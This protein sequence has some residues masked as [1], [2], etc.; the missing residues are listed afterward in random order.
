M[1]G[2]GCQVHFPSGYH[3]LFIYLKDA[4]Y[5]ILWCRAI[6]DWSHTDLLIKKLHACM[7]ICMCVCIY[8]H[9]CMYIYIYGYSR[10]AWQAAPALSSCEASVRA[11]HARQLASEMWRIS[12]QP[13]FVTNKALVLQHGVPCTHDSL[14]SRPAHWQW[15]TV[16]MRWQ[17]C[18]A[19]TV[20]VTV[21]Y[22]RVTA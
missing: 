20:S 19:M 21:W 3:P 8:I 17:I 13:A 12:N 2:I 18:G 16:P 7:H 1:V 11:K 22:V 5:A 4:C 6:D 15:F 14:S 10:E 9:A